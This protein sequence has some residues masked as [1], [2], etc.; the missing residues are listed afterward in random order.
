M[1]K[2][3]VSFMAVLALVLSASADVYVWSGTV[4]NGA[5]VSTNALQVSGL[6]DKIEVSQSAGVAVTSTV[7]VATFGA[8][9]SA[10]ETYASLTLTAN[11]IVRTRVCPTDNTGT[12]LVAATSS[13]SAAPTNVTTILT[14]PYQ[15]PII[16][17]N[18]SAVL[19]ATTIPASV[20]NTVT[21]KVFY[22]PLRR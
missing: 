11:K 2:V 20:T 7:V 21:I 18:V 10:L 5:P 9:G 15:Q 8:D 1:K 6:L 13:G 17:G 3:L 12:A 19:T 22:D 14:V 4:T 16:G